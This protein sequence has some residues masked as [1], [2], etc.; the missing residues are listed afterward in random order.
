M[1]S[2]SSI[3]TALTNYSIFHYDQA[4]VCCSASLLV[5]LLVIG[6][7]AVAG[8]LP[9]AFG[10]RQREGQHRTAAP[11]ALPMDRSKEV[12]SCS[13]QCGLDDNGVRFA[14][15]EEELGLPMSV[16]PGFMR[17]QVRTSGVLEPY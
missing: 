4:W 6:V 15:V 9:S 5:V 7:A 11:S 16:R 12:N 1:L 14:A 13:W 10:L 3:Y 8:A 17:A 2:M